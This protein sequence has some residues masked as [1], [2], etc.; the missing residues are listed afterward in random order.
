MEVQEPKAGQYSCMDNAFWLFKLLVEHATEA[1][2]TLFISL[3]M[4]SLLAESED[5]QHLFFDCNYPRCCWWHLFS[6]INIAWVFGDGFKNNVSR[7][8][9]FSFSGRK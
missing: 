3:S 9:F 7:I 2:I 6:I 5:L 8:I 1:S 4:S